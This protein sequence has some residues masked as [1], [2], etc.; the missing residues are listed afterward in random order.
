MI[1][2]SVT[3]HGDTG[4]S[5]W[6]VENGENGDEM[7]QASNFGLIYFHFETWLAGKPSIL[8]HDVH[9]TV[10]LVTVISQ[11]CFDYPRV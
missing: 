6:Q 2:G 9:F 5:K 3:E 7:K 11:P 4:S 10:Q 1:N 8:F